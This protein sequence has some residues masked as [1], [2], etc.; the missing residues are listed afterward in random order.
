MNLFEREML[1]TLSK[2]LF[3]ALAVAFR[4]FVHSAQP[5][6]STLVSEKF[7]RSQAEPTSNRAKPDKVTSIPSSKRTLSNYPLDHL[8]DIVKKFEV[9]SLTEFLSFISTEPI[10]LSPDFKTLKIE[11]T[12]IDGLYNSQIMRTQLNGWVFIIFE[13][14][15]LSPDQRGLQILS[16]KTGFKFSKL[17]KSNPHDHFSQTVFRAFS[18]SSQVDLYSEDEAGKNIS[19][20]VIRKTVKN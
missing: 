17:G 9:D 16:K 6:G 2:I 14:S 15:L 8:T 1:N 10:E 7:E 5:I 11:N 18:G 20:L 13:S 12:T 19:K 4:Q 3:F